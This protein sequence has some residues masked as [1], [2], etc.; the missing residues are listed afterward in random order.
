MGVCYDGHTP[1]ESQ[2]RRLAICAEKGF[3]MESASLQQEPPQHA[4]VFYHEN[5]VTQ[6]M[7]LCAA[8]LNTPP[9]DGH[10]NRP[11]QTP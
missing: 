3:L 6:Q 1:G 7:L 11:S 9:P 5:P 4:S 2:W 8:N 10:L